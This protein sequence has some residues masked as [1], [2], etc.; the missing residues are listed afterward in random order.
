MFCAPLALALVYFTGHPVV[1]A[2]AV[3]ALA[4]VIDA[5]IAQD[6][7]QAPQGISAP[8]A[9]VVAPES[10]Q[11]ARKPWPVAS[12]AQIAARVKVR[13]LNVYRTWLGRAHGGAPVYRVGP[14]GLR[15]V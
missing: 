2:V 13:H 1:A 5:Q 3:V 12:A 15:V 8:A 14:G 9:A 7:A 6:R 4:L 11:A 10:A